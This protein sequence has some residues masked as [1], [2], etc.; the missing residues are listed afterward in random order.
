M[1]ICGWT[2]DER[3]ADAGGHVQ[4]LY[5][6]IPTCDKTRPGFE[7]GDDGSR[8]DHA[9]GSEH[10]PNRT[11]DKRKH[12]LLWYH[13]SGPTVYFWFPRHFGG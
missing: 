2:A 1:Q 12:A 3:V 6:D 8:H 11:W 9:Q 4:Q 10:Q 13:I 5:H 7:L